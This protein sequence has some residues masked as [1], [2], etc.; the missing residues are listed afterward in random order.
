LSTTRRFDL[1]A[2]DRLICEGRG[3]DPARWSWRDDGGPAAR[4]AGGAREAMEAMARRHSLRHLVVAVIGP[5]E[6]TDAQEVAA[7]AIGTG[8]A[9]IGVTMIC[10]GKSGVMRAVSKGHADAGGTPI[11]ILPDHGPE[12]A[13]PFVAIPLPTG[14]S[15]GRNMV[16]AKA[17]R[18]LIAVGGS[19]GTLSEVAYG[20]HFGKP[21]IGLQNAPRVEGVRHVATP[22]AALEAV[23]GA[24]I[25]GA[26]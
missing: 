14:L 4:T 16:I 22:E 24:L 21:V 6:A 10:G 8:L 2:D 13:N 9:G 3:L 25:A 7:E 18:A 17:A 19:Y 20:L 23:C 12:G 5:R 11:G 15:E 1:T 26:S